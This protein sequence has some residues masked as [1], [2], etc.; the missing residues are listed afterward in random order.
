MDNCPCTSIHTVKIGIAGSK[1][2][3]VKIIIYN[4]LK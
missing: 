3:H 4:D 2:L 1:E